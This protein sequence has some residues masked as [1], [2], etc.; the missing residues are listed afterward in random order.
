MEGGCFCGA[1]RFVAT[2]PSKWAAHCHCSMCRRIHGSG[3][4]TWVGF[5]AAQV[6]LID[7]SNN[8]RWYASSPEA[9]RGSCR[10]CGSQ[11][12]FRSSKYP[13][14]LHIARAMF[15][16]P[17]DRDAVGHAFEGDHVDWMTIV[18]GPGSA[19]GSVK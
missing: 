12:F 18:G 5:E 1:V 8:L 14:E 4:V 6:S 19:E 16:G 9:G 17:I 3:A 10:E 15:D 2:P 7:E 13:G 11:M